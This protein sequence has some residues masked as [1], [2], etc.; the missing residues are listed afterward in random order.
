M[1]DGRK[2]KQDKE[3]RDKKGC[4]NNLQ[5]VKKAH[6][7]CGGCCNILAAKLPMFAFVT[8][9]ANNGNSDKQLLLLTESRVGKKQQSIG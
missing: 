8:C 7:Y 2:S 3:N 6:L 9:I 5:N 1:V 4:E